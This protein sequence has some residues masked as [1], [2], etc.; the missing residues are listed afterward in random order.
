MQQ[1]QSPKAHLIMELV[2]RLLV[3]LSSFSFLGPL[4]LFGQHP[5]SF[6]LLE[7]NPPSFLSR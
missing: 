6:H 2:L 1:W 7:D 4:F 3:S 5:L